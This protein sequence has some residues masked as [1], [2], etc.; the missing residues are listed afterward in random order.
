MNTFPVIIFLEL[1]NSATHPI[2][3]LI[4]IISY[5]YRIFYYLIHLNHS[6]G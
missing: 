4:L 5:I 2:N 3:E 1:A 6:G